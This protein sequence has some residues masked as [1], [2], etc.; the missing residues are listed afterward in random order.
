M[1][2]HQPGIS[3]KKFMLKQIFASSL[4]LTLSCCQS[5]DSN[6]LKLSN[7][8]NFSYFEISYKGGW[9]GGL[10]FFTDTNG[11]FFFPPIYPQVSGDKIKYGILPDSISQTI[12]TTIPIIKKLH[13]LNPDSLYCYDCDQVSIKL[14]KN[15]DTTKLYQAGAI[16]STVW[17]LIE[18][19][20]VFRKNEKS[21]LL[22][23][24]YFYLETAKDVS[25]PMP[26]KIPA[27]KKKN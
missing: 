1:V 9:S 12:G 5:H 21:S 3:I 26:P 19:L 8:E 6:N 24:L 15:N 11:I 18:R 10:S 2:N 27:P 23:A 16:D 7:K 20:E 14:I 13:S 4:L 22:N 17:N 25:S